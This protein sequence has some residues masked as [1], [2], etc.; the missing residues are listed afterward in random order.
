MAGAKS[1]VDVQSD[2]FVKWTNAEL[3]QVDGFDSKVSDLT[4]DFQSGTTLVQL[5]TKVVGQPFGL[6]V[7]KSPKLKLQEM[8]NLN[9]VF[10]YLSANNVKLINIAAEDV[11]DGKLKL[12]LGLLW[13]LISNFS[14]VHKLRGDRD[15]KMGAKQ[16]LLQWVNSKVSPTFVQ[17]FKADWRDGTVLA[18]LTN[19]IGRDLYGDGE[20]LVPKALVGGG[21]AQALVTAAIAAAEQ[22]L[23]ISPLLDAQTLCS[24]TCDDHSLMTYIALFCDA[25]KPEPQPDGADGAAAAGA[26]AAAAKPAAAAPTTPPPSE[27]KGERVSPLKRAP[28]WRT[29]EGI[30]LGGRCRIRVFYSTTT[31]SILVRKNTE[32]LQTL[33]EALQVHKRDDFE[34]WIPLDMDMDRE[35]RNKIFDKA[36][37]RESPL[38]FVDDEYIGGYTEIAELNSMG[39][40]QKIL[41]Y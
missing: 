6:K 29:Y 18:A 32:A 15:N 25:R 36:G 12:I 28:D 31:H 7:I 27:A 14:I 33:F 10:K 8:E 22:R 19:A 9:A 4:K 26:V 23:S 1:W 40:L 13:T 39:Q 17:N 37:T 21:D 34:P 2:T 11:H 3:A 35:F 24:D 38:V 16:L 41:D 5:V 20:E 30:D